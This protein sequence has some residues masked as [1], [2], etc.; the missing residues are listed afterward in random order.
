MLETDSIPKLRREIEASV[1][2]GQRRLDDFRRDVRKLRNQVRRIQPHTATA[3][4]LVATDGGENAVGFDPL[5]L[6]LIRVV[7]SSKNEYCLEVMSAS[8]DI[9][10]V[11]ERLR[12]TDSQD[13]P[14]LSRLME[15]MHV[16]SLAELSH[17][18]PKPPAE[19]KPSWI[20]VYRE[21]M[22]WATLLELVRR[23][24]GTDTIV[25]RDGFLR[26]KVFAG[27]KFKEYRRLLDEAIAD[28]LR[29]DRRRMFV[30]GV[31][32]HSK[33][34]DAYRLAMALEGVLRTSYP[35]YLEVPRELETKVYKW[36]EY[37]RGD[38]QEVES[39]EANKFVGG[40]MYFVKFGA[41]PQDPIWAVDILESQTDQ[42]A[43]ILGYMLQDALDGFP[44]PFYPMCLQRAHD[45]AAL[46]DFDV[47]IIRD[48]M[49][50]AFRRTLGDLKHVMDDYQ[51]E[52]HDPSAARYGR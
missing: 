18:I 15:A 46:V 51:L 48:R 37:A 43:R 50:D 32:K 8:T 13:R 29:R 33:V 10:Q 22:E 30:A 23:R 16:R 47:A 45:N 4:S 41:R 6:H 40:R 2:D 21:L 12:S 20:Q 28:Q 9:S 44:V 39:G 49:F 19:P 34:L 11:D 14:P 35:A 27:E 24:F 52:T 17:M 25:I 31:A 38:E 42:A 36:A 7:D 3:V 1:E 5:M 26:S